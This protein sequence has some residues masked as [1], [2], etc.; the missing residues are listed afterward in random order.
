MCFTSFIWEK[1]SGSSNAYPPS[2]G[3]GSEGIETVCACVRACVY[4]LCLNSTC[5]P[6]SRRRRPRGWRSSCPLTGGG[7]SPRRS[8]SAAV[9][10][11]PSWW[12][13]RGQTRTRVHIWRAKPSPVRVVHVVVRRRVSEADPGLPDVL[14]AVDGLSVQRCVLPTLKWLIPH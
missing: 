2:I 9:S 4:S 3:Q 6:R 1:P 8:T 11:A 10:A 7:T 12:N 13:K 5:S 14:A